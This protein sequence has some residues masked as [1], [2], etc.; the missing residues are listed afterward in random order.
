MEW[1]IPNLIEILSAVSDK[2]HKHMKDMNLPGPFHQLWCTDISFKLIQKPS[3]LTLLSKMNFFGLFEM[4]ITL[5][6]KAA[7]LLLIACWR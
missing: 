2:H 5:R 3:S 4:S 7:I 6:Q 1:Q